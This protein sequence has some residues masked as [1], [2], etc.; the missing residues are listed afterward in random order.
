VVITVGGEALVGRKVLAME[1]DVEAEGEDFRTED[2]DQTSMREALVERPGMD[3]VPVISLIRQI[4]FLLMV[5]FGLVRVDRMLLV[6]IEATKGTA[7]VQ[8][9]VAKLVITVI[10]MPE[11]LFQTIMQILWLP[12]GMVGMLPMSQD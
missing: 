4:M 2:E 1:G 5:C 6:E 7:A 3:R 10:I 9:L 12:M 8:T 11:D